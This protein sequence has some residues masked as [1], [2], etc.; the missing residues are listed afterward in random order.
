[1]V[2]EAA[3]QEALAAE[4]AALSTPVV[5]VVSLLVKFE[6]HLEQCGIAADFTS[7]FH[8]L[9]VLLDLVSFPGPV[10]LEN[11]ITKVALVDDGFGVKF[12]LLLDAILHVFRVILQGGLQERG[13]KK[14]IQFEECS[15][16][17]GSP[18]FLLT[19]E[20]IFFMR[21]LAL[22]MKHS[23]VVSC[24]W[25]ELKCSRNIAMVLILRP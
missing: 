20:D 8:T 23:A 9:I 18:E 15:A 5:I 16:L 13:G 7:E 25:C 21:T 12:P 4:G 19:H 6:V 1:M 3:L 2:F 22:H 24:G 10:C 17:N 14:R 11:E